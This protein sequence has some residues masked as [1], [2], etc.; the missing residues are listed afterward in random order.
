MLDTKTKFILDAIIK[1]DINNFSIITP[2]GE[3]VQIK[4]PEEHVNIENCS[5]EILERIKERVKRI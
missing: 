4:P 2:E 5:K 1:D 3:E